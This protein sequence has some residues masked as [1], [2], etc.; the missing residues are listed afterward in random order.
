[1]LSAPISGK[2]SETNCCP[3]A[4]EATTLSVRTSLSSFPDRAETP[5]HFLIS[6]RTRTLRILVTKERRR[7]ALFSLFLH[8]ATEGLCSDGF[9][10]FST[11]KFGKKPRCS[12]YEKKSVLSLSTRAL[13]TKTKRTRI[14]LSP[15]FFLTPKIKLPII[16]FHLPSFVHLAH[17]FCLTT[18]YT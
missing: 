4:H 16:K 17:H 2:E 5:S 10:T 14:D 8:R 11:E 15:F 7:F 9:P 6:E 3:R 1:M 18:L 12:P 13:P